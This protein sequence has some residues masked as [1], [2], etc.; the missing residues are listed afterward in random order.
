M[1]LTRRT[2]ASHAFR[3]NRRYATV[4]LSALGTGRVTGSSR[5]LVPLMP[6]HRALSRVPKAGRLLRWL[7]FWLGRLCIVQ[8]SGKTCTMSENRVSIA[9]S[10]LLSSN[11]SSNFENWIN[12]LS[13]SSDTI[14]VLLSWP[15]G[16]EANMAGTKPSLI[17]EQAVTML[18]WSRSAQRWYR[19][20]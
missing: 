17:R 18:S 13:E 9:S 5:L 8:I 1:L 3:L 7:Y 16:D 2:D 10:Y 19:Y 12:R 20:P 4:V 11:L 15:F 14:A 6:I